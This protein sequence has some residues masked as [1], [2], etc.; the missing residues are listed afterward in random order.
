[1]N[2]YKLLQIFAMANLG[3]FASRFLGVWGGF[4]Q[5]K[6]KGTVMIYGPA[7]RAIIVFVFFKLIVSS[8]TTVTISKIKYMKANMV[9][10][11]GNVTVVNKVI[12]AVTIC[13]NLLQPATVTA[14]ATSPRYQS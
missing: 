4:K 14:F 6:V 1:M 2:C 8:V 5:Q 13:Y 12:Y 7:N 3:C 11:F 10:D 9:K